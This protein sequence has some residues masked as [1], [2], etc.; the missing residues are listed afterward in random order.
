MAYKTLAEIL[1]FIEQYPEMVKAIRKEKPSL[2]VTPT[3]EN[4]IELSEYLDQCL[5]VA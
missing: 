4:L 2:C 3:E 5:T 1:L